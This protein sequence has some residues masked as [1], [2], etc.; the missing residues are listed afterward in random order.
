MDKS[1][2]KKP[3]L[4]LYVWDEFSPD[5]TKGLAFAIAKDEQDAREQIIAKCYG[6][7]SDWGAVKVF[8]LNERIAFKCYGGA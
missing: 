8:P 5:Y 3:V 7:P 4:K 6:E 1:V 2:K